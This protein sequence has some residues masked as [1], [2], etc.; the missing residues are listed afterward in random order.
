M[1]HFENKQTG[2]LSLT[3]YSGLALI[4]QCFSTEQMDAVID[5]LLPESQGMRTYLSYHVEP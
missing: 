5:P 3:S 1:P 4:D 2:E